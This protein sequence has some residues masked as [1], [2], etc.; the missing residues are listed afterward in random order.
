MN[1][2]P[3]PPYSACSRR[4]YFDITVN[5]VIC[6]QKRDS[7]GNL[8]RTMAQLIG[9]HVLSFGYEVVQ[10]LSQRALMPRHEQAH[11]AANLLVK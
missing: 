7:V 4:T 11:F 1:R 9:L 5:D 2:C 3:V 10:V 6:V 8:Q